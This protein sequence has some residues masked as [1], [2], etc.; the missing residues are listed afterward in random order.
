MIFPGSDNLDFCLFCWHYIA[1]CIV[2]S[3]FHY[4]SWSMKLQHIF[5]GLL[6]TQNLLLTREYKIQ[7]SSTGI[8]SAPVC[9][10]NCICYFI[11]P[12]H[13]FSIDLPGLCLP[14]EWCWIHVRWA[15]IYVRQVLRP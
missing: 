14:K 11:V 5:L 2:T 4:S 12:L 3:T 10:K 15:H 13:M 9:V 6:E 1:S 7:I 8:K